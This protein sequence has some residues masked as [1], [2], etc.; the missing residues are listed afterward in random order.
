M[1]EGLRFSPWD[2]RSL[3]ELQVYD[4][5]ECVFQDWSKQSFV[6]HAIQNHPDSSKYLSNIQDDSLDDIDVPWHEN[7]DEKKPFDEAFEG[8]DLNIEYQDK[9]NH[10][11]DLTFEPD[12]AK[13]ELIKSE[14]SA[15]APITK[16][17]FVQLEPLESTDLNETAQSAN[18]SKTKSSPRKQKKVPK[19]DDDIHDEGDDDPDY[20]PSHVDEEEMN[21]EEN[22]DLKTLKEESFILLDQPEPNIDNVDEDV[23]LS[24]IKTKK[25]RG[26][27]VVARDKSDKEVENTKECWK[28]LKTFVT[29]LQVI[30]HLD[31]IHDDIVH[32]CISC[33]IMFDQ[34]KHKEKHMETC[35][36]KCW[37]CWQCGH[38]F[39]RMRDLKDH[40]RRVHRS[41]GSGWKTQ[42]DI[43][44]TKTCWRCSK[45]F[46]TTLQVIIHLDEIHDDIKHAC[47]TCGI[48]F[49]NKGHKDKHMEKCEEKCWKC[50]ICGKE[51]RQMLGLTQHIR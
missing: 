40:I 26:P 21:L 25:K 24:E 14:E 18:P 8:N 27:Y 30:K 50:W 29:T 3:Y 38:K 28:C 44:N 2:V 34:N 37:K 51:S 17:S 48:M 7:P 20:V 11:E 41:S 32:A 13:Q 22:E 9:E 4:C 19:Y 49:I 35:N 12:S 33:G 42:K 1:D 16:D 39:N 45:S 10:S 23:P 6:N 43:E 31:E 36:E 47:V 5:P 15:V 46:E